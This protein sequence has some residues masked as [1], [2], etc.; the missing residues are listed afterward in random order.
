[1][2]H[3][4]IYGRSS[5]TMC[6]KNNCSFVFFFSV[7]Y[8]VLCLCRC[9]RLQKQ[10]KLF[11]LK[12]QMKQLGHQTCLIMVIVNM[13][14]K[15]SWHLTATQDVIT[16]WILMSWTFTSS[17]FVI[18]IDILVLSVGEIPMNSPSTKTCLQA[19]LHCV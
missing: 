9:C 4:H 16:V 8:V 5:H 14:P 7:C 19:L 17:V 3:T 1:M 6:V 18:N 11:S 13:E 12:D 10:H 2:N 15:L